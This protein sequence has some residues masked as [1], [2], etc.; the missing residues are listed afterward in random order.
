[1]INGMVETQ[2]DDLRTDQASFATIWTQPLGARTD[3]DPPAS[4]RDCNIAMT[5]MFGRGAPAIEQ[6]PAPQSARTPGLEELGTKRRL[7]IRLLAVVP[8]I[9]SP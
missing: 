1:L 3:V 8:H 7:T 5:G 6:T 9:G 2:A 4:G